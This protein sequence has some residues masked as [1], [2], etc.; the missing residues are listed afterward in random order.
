MAL[1]SGLIAKHAIFEKK[2]KKKICVHHA[3]SDVKMQ[4]LL[5]LNIIKYALL[6]FHENI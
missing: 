2:K 1:A 4:I 3:I 5:N 6:L